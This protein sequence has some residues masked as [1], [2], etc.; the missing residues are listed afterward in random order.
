VGIGGVGYNGAVR[1]GTNDLGLH[2]EMIVPLNFG[3]PPLFIPW[4][5]IT[6]ARKKRKKFFV[7]Y[8]ILELDIGSPKATTLT[9]LW[10]YAGHFE[11]WIG[12]RIVSQ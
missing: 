2:L 3:A 8:D 12:S 7:S 9:I 4:S 5:E 11:P 10:R 6:E 1:F